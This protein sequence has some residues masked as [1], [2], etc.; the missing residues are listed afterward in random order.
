MCCLSADS[1]SVTLGGRRILSGV[2]LKV[3]PGEVVG[4]LGR[5][6]AGK[7]T[8]YRCLLGLCP[9]STGTLHVNGAYVGRREALRVMGYLPQES[10]LPPDLS[11]ERSAGMILGRAG[12]RSLL[13]SDE[14]ASR[15]LP[16]KAR[17]LSVGERRYVECLIA[18]SLDRPV[19]L[20]DEPFSQVEPLYCER[21]VEHMRIAARDKAVIVTDHLYRTV[22]KAV[23]RLRLMRNGVLDDVPNDRRSLAECGYAPVDG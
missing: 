4:I 14:R 19:C 7:S 8:L 20:L 18:L 23:D 11:V 9:A 22:M 3:D 1:I 21:L 6:G 12:D 17:E 15:L 2:Y 13:R 16:R 5:N 10:Y